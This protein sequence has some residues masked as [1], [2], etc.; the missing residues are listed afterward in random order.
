[1]ENDLLVKAAKR[2]A[3]T[4]PENT[5]FSIKRFMGRLFKEVSTEIKEVPYNI[6]K[7]S[8]NACVVKVSE[9]KDYTPSRNFSND[10]AKA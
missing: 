9:E 2:Q 5:I 7:N 3:V 6:D 10:S 4:N 8:S 1:M